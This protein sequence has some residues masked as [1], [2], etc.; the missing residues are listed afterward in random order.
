MVSTLTGVTCGHTCPYRRYLLKKLL[1]A[2]PLAFSVFFAAGTGRAVQASPGSLEGSCAAIGVTA[3][4]PARSRLT[5]S[6][7]KT[8]PGRRSVLGATNLLHS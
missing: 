2:A 7:L 6:Q 5:P 8:A 4:A 1:L 3:T